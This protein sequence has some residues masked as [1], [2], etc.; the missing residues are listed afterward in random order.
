MDVKWQEYE[1]KQADLK[2]HFKRQYLKVLSIFFAYNIVA[3]L[4]IYF[5]S[6]LIA[7]MGFVAFIISTGLS[8]YIMLKSI[9]GLKNIKLNQE[10]LLQQEAPVGKIRI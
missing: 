5:I 1:K 10:R 9:A 8:L 3:D 6:D 4:V 7:P 2:K